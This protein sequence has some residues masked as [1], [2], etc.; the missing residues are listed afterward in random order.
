MTLEFQLTSAISNKDISRLP[1]LKELVQAE[2]APLRGKMS[3]NYSRHIAALL[4]ELESV[5]PDVKPDVV[6]EVKSK[7]SIAT[8]VS[9][10][11][12]A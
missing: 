1:H 6:T 2:L 10:Y 5:M 11:F 7:P 3:Q 4:R 12:R 8:S 9:N